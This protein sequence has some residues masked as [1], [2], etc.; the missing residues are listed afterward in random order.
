V[1][2]VVLKDLVVDS[3]EKVMMFEHVLRELAQS[4][5][6]SEYVD[7]VF[8]SNLIRSGSSTRYLLC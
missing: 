7:G 6:H 2:W 1:L 4:L 3:V 5:K 8:H